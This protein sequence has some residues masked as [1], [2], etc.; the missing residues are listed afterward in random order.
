MLSSADYCG[1]VG[2]LEVIQGDWLGILNI[3]RSLPSCTL[4]LT[5]GDGLEDLWCTPG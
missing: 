3:P 4:C 2:N 5:N 1:D